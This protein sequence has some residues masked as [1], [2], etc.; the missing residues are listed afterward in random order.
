[1][2]GTF[3]ISTV[4]SSVSLRQKNEL[5]ANVDSIKYAKVATNIS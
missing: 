1:M 4:E 5:S 3:C 2:A